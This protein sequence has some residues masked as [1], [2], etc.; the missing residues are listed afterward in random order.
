MKIGIPKALLYSKYHVFAE[1]FFTELGAEILV[2]PDTNKN[3]LDEGTKTCL[4]E[5][6]LPIKVFHGHVS[7]LK[8]KCD[9][10]L[11]PRFMKIEN[12]YIC[13]M[14]C[15]LSEVVKNN[16]SNLPQI[17]DEPIYSLN[18]KELFDWS[19][20]TGGIIT[21]NKKAIKDA[22]NEAVNKQKIYKPG[23]FD[24]GYMYNVALIGHAYNINDSFIN[25]KLK[26]KLNELGVGVITE[27][28]ADNEAIKR[29]IDALFKRPFWHFASRSYGAAVSLFREGKID[30][31][32]YISSFSCGIDSV[33]T[34]LVKNETC[35]FPFLILKI[36]E[37]T[38]EAGFN[39]R[40]EA[41]FDMLKRR[42]SN[43]Y[44]IP[45]HGKHLSGDKSAV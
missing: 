27:E 12:R 20:K 8:N 11:M 45:A 13:P 39:T 37:H 40:I 35:D 32:V 1:T 10:I 29:E 16:I 15:G 43:A 30:G 42:N 36:D 7:W 19:K 14:F 41:F 6:C 3:I 24:K 4:D 25:M 28:Y 44:H 18:T 2:S 34:E 21:E 31:I 26:K 5:A 9:Y 38:G 22:F 23:F 33:I 17:I